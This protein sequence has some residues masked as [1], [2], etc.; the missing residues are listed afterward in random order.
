MRSSRPPLFAL[1]VALTGALGLAPALAHARGG[2]ALDWHAPEECPSAQT[3][4]SMV[5]DFLGT[6]PA[7]VRELG[8]SASVER[9]AQNRYWLLLRIDNAGQQTERSL[10][11]PDCTTLARA[12]ALLIAIAIDPEVEARVA[13]QPPV[14]PPAAPPPVAPPPVAPPPKSNVAPPA[15][16][17]REAAEPADESESTLVLRPGA[18]L[19]GVLDAGTLHGTGFGFGGAF[20][21]RLDILRLALGAQWFLPRT[22]DIASTPESASAKLNALTTVAHACIA[23]NVSRFDLGPCAALEIGVIWGDA[24]GIRDPSAGHA[25]WL[26]FGGGLQA[27]WHFMHGW[28]LFAG[29]ALLAP[30]VRRSFYVN[31]DDGPVSVH[32]VP[33]ATGRV[34]LGIAFEVE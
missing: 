28:S 7:S 17:P 21:L 32:Q 2:L 11:D 18:A 19:G 6:D 34:D 1:C 27:R 23:W 9:D 33:A 5:A 26:A 8:A 13:A 4:Q 29:G 31:T 14:V 15:A 16:P 30:H 24:R 25:L 12:S 10:S 22:I 20:T 3:V